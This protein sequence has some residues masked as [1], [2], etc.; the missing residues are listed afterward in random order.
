MTWKPGETRLFNSMKVLHIINA[1]T[2]GGAEI[3]LTNSLAP[4]GLQDHAENIL[5][6]FQGESELL[7]KIDKRVTVI[8]L[9]Y[10]GWYSFGSL[11]KNI[12]RVIKEHKP[13]IIH[14]HLNPAGWYTSLAKPK[15]IPQVHTL[16]ISYSDNT[17]TDKVRLFFERKI[18]LQRKDANLITL[19][20]LLREDLKACL[21]IKGNVFVLSNFIADEFFEPNPPT[22]PSD[23]FKLV[24]VGNMRPQKNYDYLL[25][26]FSHLKDLPVSVDVYGHG[27][28]ATFKQRAEKEN[29]AV[30]FMGPIK[31]PKDIYWKYNGFIM[32]SKFEGF[33][34]TAYEA[35]ASGLPLFLSDLGAFKS[36]IKDNAVYFGL[37]DA[38][39][40]AETIRNTLKN[41]HMNNMAIQARH[42]AEETVKR[43]AY[44]TNLLKIYEQ[45]LERQ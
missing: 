30:R 3:L 8:N 9:Q 20:E 12:R 34:L 21:N 5:L 19:S 24:A 11:L 41:G 39:A 44:I 32:P 35:M 37:N 16:H 43:K 36:L 6:Y 33:G 7:D 2:I 29:L 25:D 18:L 38:A 4:G 27:D 31:N 17:D 42:Y 26:I 10:K 40:A 1:L 23:I 14:T 28:D 22:P 13:D 15:N 45:V